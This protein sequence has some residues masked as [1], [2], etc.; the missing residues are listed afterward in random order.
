MAQQRDRPYRL[1]TYK[2]LSE[3]MVQRTGLAACDFSQAAGR[4]AM[5]HLLGPLADRTFSESGMLIPVHVKYMQDNG[6]G[7]TSTRSRRTTSTAC[8]AGC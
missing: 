8:C 2:E 3:V 1:T 7:R 4:A 6:P 5:G